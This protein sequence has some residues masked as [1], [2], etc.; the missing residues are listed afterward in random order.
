MGMGI[1]MHA[2]IPVSSLP[3]SKL[4]ESSSTFTVPQ[5]VTS[6]TLEAWGGGGGGGYSSDNGR[7]C[8]GGGGGAYSRNVITVTPGQILTITVGAGGSGDSG[9]HNGGDSYVLL[10]DGTTLVKAVGGKGVADNSSDGA[11]GGQASDCVGTA[12][13]GGNGGSGSGQGGGEGS[14]GGGGGAGSSGAGKTGGNGSYRNIFGGNA[15]SGGNSTDDHGGK[16]GDGVGTANPGSNG[17]SYGGGGGGGK[18]RNALGGNPYQGG[19]GAPGLVRISA[20]FPAPPVI[21]LYNA[22]VNSICQGEVAVKATASLPVLSS[23]GWEWIIEGQNTGTKTNTPEFF[24]EGL[25][26]GRYAYKVRAYYERISWFGETYDNVYDDSKGTATFTV[27]IVPDV[28]DKIISVCSGEEFKI[29]PSAAQGDVLPATPIYS[30]SIPADIPQGVTGAAASSTNLSFI[31]NTLVNTTDSPQTVTYIVTPRSTLGSCQGHTFTITVTVYPKPV[32]S[33]KEID[34]C[35]GESVKDYDPASGTAFAGITNYEWILTTTSHPGAISNPPQ[36][37]LGNNINIGTLINTSPTTATLYYTV[38]P[39]AITNSVGCAGT[40]FTLAVI[41]YPCPEIVDPGE[42]CSGETLQL[43]LKYRDNTIFDNA[44]GGTY[45]SSDTSI[46]QIDSN[47][48]LSTD[49]DE[50]EEGK[51]GKVTVTY[52]TANGCVTEREITITPRTKLPEIRWD[53]REVCPIDEDI[54]HKPN[55]NSII[56]TPWNIEDEN[57]E[58]F[59]NHIVWDSLVVVNHEPAYL[60]DSNNNKIPIVDEEG[61]QIIDEEEGELWKIDEVENVKHLEWITWYADNNGVKGERLRSGLD[62]LTD[63]KMNSFFQNE[64]HEYEAYWATITEPGKCESKPRKV[65]V[66]IA[67]NTYITVIPLRGYVQPAGTEQL[68]L[69]NYLDLNLDESQYLDWYTS[70]DTTS[71]AKIANPPEKLD[72]TKAIDTTYWLVKA[73]SYGCRSE[74]TEFHIQLV[75]MPTISIT[76]KETLV[77]PRYPVDVTVTISNGTAPYNFTIINMNTGVAD[78]QSE[79]E[80]AV[81][82]FTTSPQATVNRR[83]TK[84][85]DAF[86]ENV[87]Y[88]PYGLNVPA[89]G[90]FDQNTLSVITTEIT[91]ISPNSGPT[92]GGI[93][94]GIP[95][96]PIK[97]DGTI[98]I[99][100]SGFKPFETS[101][102]PEVTFDGIPADNI[103]VVDNNTIYCT[104]PPHVSGYVTVAVTAVCA[105]TTL[106]DG[107]RYEP[108]NVSDVIPAYGPVTG[109]TEITIRG[110]GLLGTTGS[111]ELVTV[112][113]AGIPAKIVSV[114]N[115]EIKCITDASTVSILGDIVINNGIE[116]RVFTDRFTY[117]PV[118]FVENGYWSEPHKWETQTDYHI[119]PYPGADVQINANCVQDIDVDME[120]ITV[121][122]G[123]MYTIA[124]EKILKANDFTL[125]ANA[126]FLNQNPANSGNMQAVR[127][128]MEHL[129]SKGRNWYVSSPVQGGEIPL[130]KEALGKSISGDDLE[131][132]AGNTWRV[133]SYHEGMHNWLPEKADSIFYTGLGYTAYSSETDIAVKFSGIYSDGDQETQF[134][135]TRQD[136]GHEKRGFNLVGNPF[137]SYWRWTS[138]EAKEANLYST[139]WYR[140][141]VGGVYEFWSYNASGDV[142][143][144]PGW[145]NATPT[146]SYS[147]AYIAP[148]QAFWVRLIDGKSSGILTFKDNHRSHADHAS[149]FLKTTRAANNNTEKRP[150]LRLTVNN[151]FYIDETVIYADPEAK[152]EFDIYDSDKLFAERGIEIFTIPY[153][154]S[155]ELTINGLPEITNGMEIPLGFQA[156]EGGSFSFHAKEILNLDTLDVFLIDKWRNTETNLRC[157]NYQFTSSSV[158]VTDRFSIRFRHSVVSGLPNETDVNQEAKNGN[159]LLA[160]IYN[161]GQIVVV[162]HLEGKKGNTEKITV[163]D[164]TGRKIAEQ[165]I[166]VGERTMLK[167]KLPGGTYVLRA[168]EC[169]T[170]VILHQ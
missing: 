157:K 151:D 138:E 91:K 86:T 81:Y 69:M 104:P 2:Q 77:C 75:P 164:T 124:Y 110:T 1:V 147:M 35:N 49:V 90:Y 10:S 23:N 169:T 97:E 82:T 41:V 76:P 153:S 67:V 50:D 7:A 72:P 135:V 31:S 150:L 33:Y 71:V 44:N 57:R 66:K 83:I 53:F 89:V 117:Y 155:R 121:C 14:G 38:T 111:E 52:T 95:E 94:T 4:Y 58:Y 109:N 40:E 133:E 144:A 30:W 108:I 93:Y 163:F 18:R 130:I 99:T 102:T 74:A 123:K 64:N 137:P 134:N 87:T 156:E 13:S 16:G 140:T 159:E 92:S 170:K 24:T 166:V 78:E 114:D 6:V 96:A 136:D 101:S 106:T 127:Q 165:S 161:D 48:M 55:E 19:N 118:K 42:I 152:K 21:S 88:S 70:S 26:P 148:M 8:G 84:F 143:V 25:A 32:I 45:T 162:L 79:R 47:G 22:N 160:Y 63:E 36:S 131:T 59:A 80:E 103:E 60:L 85:S 141:Q 29:T 146:G 34:I 139:I 46:V 122:P 68:D 168:A 158:S 51:G 56:A 132:I 15:G 27:I 12:Y 167:K 105:T 128:N 73:D 115:I 43:Q 126:S 100:G 125:Q 11:A 17:S 112:T 145:E 120:S 5:G 28:Q 154:S 61:N 113:I 62:P 149:N 54:D 9:T 119:L 116:S 39:T 3:I 107:Y 129:L 37:G 20:T 98:A 65:E 142:A